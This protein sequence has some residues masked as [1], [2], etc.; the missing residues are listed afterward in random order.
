MQNLV[1][2]LQVFNRDRD[3]WLLALKYQT[4]RSDMFA[5]FRGTCHLFYEDWPAN[6]SLNEAP[7]VWNCGDFHLNNLGSYK[8]DNRLVYFNINDFDEAALA[9][10]TWDM[11]RLFTCLLISTRLQHLT[12]ANALTL[13]QSFLEIY[14]RTLVKAHI[15]TLEEEEVSGFVKDLRLQV[16]NRNRKA[17][18]DALTVFNGEKRILRIDGKHFTPAT[19]MERAAVV[20]AVGRWTAKEPAPGFFKVLDVAHRIAGVGSLGVKRYV[21]LVEGKG[22]PDQNYLL[23]LKQEIPSC[24]Y[25]FLRLPQPQWANQ[26]ER[27]VSIQQW[28]Q[29][30]PPALLAAV[31]LGGEG[32]VL[33]E[34]QP[35]EDKVQAESLAAKLERWEEVVR[36]I[37]KVLAWD[38][39]HGGGHHGSATAPMLI[40]FAQTMHWRE[41]LLGY[42]QYYAAQVEED[43]RTFCSAFDSGSFSSQREGRATG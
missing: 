20:D 12:Q 30:M 16:K 37:A 25:P 21:L 28:T 6:S 10:C 9:P 5:F 43:Y 24:L 26:A 36:V 40:D 31:E 35:R 1:E 2:R 42:A 18:L 38:Q 22:S 34:L 32:Y 27:V 14:A 17:F 15:R 3:P 41:D 29:V 33:R 4:M 19:E 11:A 13:C 39:L 7:A 23:D 8:A